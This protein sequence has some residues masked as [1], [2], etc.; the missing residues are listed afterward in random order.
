MLGAAAAALREA[1]RP[2][3]RAAV[4]AVHGGRGGV[5]VTFVATH[6]AAA[7]AR[8]GSTILLDA[9]PV[10]GDVAL[11]LGAPAAEADDGRPAH[12]LADVVA[13][14][15]DAGPDEVRGALWQHAS[16]VGILLPPSPEEA[17]RLGAEALGGVLGAVTGAAD[18]VV[19]HLPREVGPV[20]SSLAAAADRLLEVLT[21]DVAT[22]HAASRAVEA[23]APL[24]LGDRLAFVVNRAARSEVVPGD[25]ERV[26]GTPA[27]VVIPFDRAAR[28]AGERGRLCPPKGRIAR[29]FDRLAEALLP[30]AA[31]AQP[32]HE[33]P[34]E[35]TAPVVDSVPTRG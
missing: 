9:D 10:F 15:E 8:R 5:G 31:V 24:H 14:G 22:F 18:A 7:L 33:A 19:M 32:P 13:L 1:R 23:F 21:L 4:V 6:L 34:S 30:A 26:F 35:G 27:T 17:V 3:G 20:T 16:G 11:S 25:V 28:A 29:R 12:T 2:A